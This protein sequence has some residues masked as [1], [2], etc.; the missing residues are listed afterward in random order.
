MR[1]FETAENGIG[2]FRNNFSKQKRGSLKREV[3]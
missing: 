1:L 3:S 2:L